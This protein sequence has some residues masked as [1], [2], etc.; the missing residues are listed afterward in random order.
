MAVGTHEAFDVTAF[1]SCQSTASRIT[2]TTTKM[3]TTRAMIRDVRRLGALRFGGR[4]YKFSMLNLV[5]TIIPRVTYNYNVNMLS[6]I[7]AI[8][9]RRS[10]RHFKPDPVP[11][12]VVDQM[13]EAA[14]RHP[15]AIDSHGGSR[16]SQ[17]PR[18]EKRCFRKP[19]SDQ[20]TF[21]KHRS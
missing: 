9:A 6:V 8:R 7:E 12:E 20:S 14:S 18:R 21:R 10:V 11:A 3:P 17:S 5:K 4:L 16:S 15:E 19:R 13:L 2:A 1:T